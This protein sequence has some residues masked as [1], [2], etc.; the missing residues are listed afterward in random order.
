MT[1]L[2]CTREPGGAERARL[3][4]SGFHRWIALEHDAAR[5][6][7]SHLRE[8]GGEYLGAAVIEHRT[9]RRV[10]DRGSGA[11][12]TNAEHLHRADD[13]AVLLGD[14]PP[15]GPA[16][17]ALDLAPLPRLKDV[18]ERGRGDE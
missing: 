8:Q 2:G 10:Q 1:A 13:P 12:R 3:G 16:A 14:D 18:G 15:R 11:H 9:A 17:D 6:C 4:A 5:R 7:A